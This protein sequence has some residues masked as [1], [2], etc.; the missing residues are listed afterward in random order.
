MS[1]V[2]LS[3]ATDRVGAAITQDNIDEVE[4]ELAALIGP[5]VG[6]R[7]ET[8]N[9]YE[10]RPRWHTVDGLYLSRRTNA[11]VV[12]NAIVGESAS[13]LTAGTDYRLLDH[14][15]IE[16][17]TNGAAW[18]DVV[19]VTYEPNDEETVRGVIFDLL[20]YRQT[21]SG[22]QSI[23]IGAYSETYFGPTAGQDTADPVLGALLRRILPA[24]GLGLTS[25]YRFAA[26]RRERSLI[27]GG[28][29]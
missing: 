17:V 6:S 14:M 25:P 23:R 1:L 13:T 21:P 29:S 2:S 19:A 12:T 4:E 28:A 27:T 15:L 9:L 7:T 26:H 18:L 16:H 20:T 10:R 22:T 3:D 24:A 5:L 11:A 8:F